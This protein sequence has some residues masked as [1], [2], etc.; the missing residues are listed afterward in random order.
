MKDITLHHAQSR[1]LATFWLQVGFTDS[2]VCHPRLSHPLNFSR[3]HYWPKQGL[4]E[5]SRY[6]GNYQR[7]RGYRVDSRRHSGYSQDCVCLEAGLSRGA[8][9]K[10]ESGRVEPKISTLALIAITIGVSLG[11]L[12]GID[13]R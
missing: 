12:V 1:K 11:K 9:S 10:I 2:I 8:L 7:N 13:I 4:Q 6:E 3:G 5:G